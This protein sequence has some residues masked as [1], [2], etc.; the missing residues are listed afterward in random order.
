MLRK[1]D[2]R[3][4]V[5]L[6]GCPD[7]APLA[8]SLDFNLMTTYNVLEA[9]R[10]AGVPR[11]VLASTAHVT[12][13]YPAGSY[14]TPTLPNRPDSF[15][16]VSKVAAEALVRMYVEKYSLTGVCIRIG[17]VS[18][19]PRKWRHL[20][21]W[22]SPRDA[23]ELFHRSAVSNV[24]GFLVTYGFSNNTRARWSR[25]GWAELAYVPHDR[26]DDYEANLSPQEAAGNCYNWQ[27]G[28]F[29][30]RAYT[31]RVLGDL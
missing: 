24:S 28:H 17:T 25:D 7:E 27:G 23:G 20:A 6:A 30:D 10:R 18:R 3:V 16:G 31:D 26:A 29:A 1:R 12:G 13:F 2:Q 14:V 15:Y 19:E 11:I 8:Q 5:V 21:T 22:L 9:C 4:A